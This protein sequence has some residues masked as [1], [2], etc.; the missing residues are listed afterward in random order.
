MVATAALVWLPGNGITGNHHLAS[1]PVVDEALRLQALRGYGVLDTPPEEAFDRLTRLAARLCGAPMAS[2]TLVDEDR[3]WFKSRLGLSFAQTPRDISFCTHGIE[4]REPTVV[5]DAASDERFARNPLVLGEPHLRFYACVPLV[6]PQGWAIGTLAVMDTR[7]R[8]LDPL[9]LEALSALAEQVMTLFELRLREQA[10]QRL[11]A[12]REQMHAALLRQTETLQIAGHLARVGGWIIEIGATQ[13]IWS[14]TVA[15]IHGLEAGRTVTLD[16]ASAFYPEPWRERLLQC[17]RL[18][19]R[20]G[21]SFDE[22]MQIVNVRG[23]S[24]WVRVIGQAVRDGSGR[25]VRVH[26]VLQDISARKRTEDELARS[27]ENFRR[28][29]DAM[30][31]VVWTALPDGRVDYVN[32]SM[33]RFSDVDVPD[34]ERGFNWL[35]TLHPDDRERTKAAWLES[36]RTGKPYQVEY[37]LRH[38]ATTPGGTPTHRWYLSQAEPVRDEQGRVVRWFGSNIDIHESREAERVLLD[39]QR[40]L[41]TLLDN[42]PGMAYRC[43]ISRNWHMDFV[44]EGA[45]ELTGYA[46]AQ[47]VGE[48][49]VHFGDMVVPEDRE[50]VWLE[51]EQAVKARQKFRL[52]Y[53]IRCADGSIKWVQEHGQGREDEDGEVRRLE[54]IITDITELRLAED[55]VRRDAELRAEIVRVQQEIAASDLPMAQ[56]LGLIARSAMEITRATGG[57]IEL[58]EGERLVCH[59]SI[60]LSARPLGSSVGLYDSLGGLAARS[61]QALICDDSETD[62]RVDRR[63]SRRFGARSIVVAPLR[64]AASVIGVLRVTATEPGHFGQ[65]DL[66]HVQILMESLGSTVQRLRITDR[67]RASESQYRLLF[68]QNPSPMWV[69]LTDGLRIQ[70]VNPAAVRHYGYSEAEFLQMSVKDLWPLDQREEIRAKA[71]EQLAMPGTFLLDTRHTRKDGSV[72]DVEVTANV[73]DFNG[74]SAHLCLMADVTERRRV[75]RDLA[76]VSRAQRMLSACN[77]ALIRTED[78]ATLLER[79][80]GITV[81][82]GGYRMAWVGYAMDDA[83]C[84]VVPVSHAGADNGFL[85]GVQVSWSAES[86]YGQGAVGQTVR[87]RSVVIVRELGLSPTS[88]P[89]GERERSHG[90]HSLICLPL[91]RRAESRAFGVLCLFAAEISEVGAE[92]RALLVELADDLA[93]GIEHLR[94]QAEQRRL[95]DTVLK[96]SAAVSASAGEAFFEQLVRNMTEALGASSGFVA[97]YLAAEP[98]RAHTLAAIVQGERIANESFEL[99]GTPCERL[100]EQDSFIHLKGV[101]DAFPA[102]R[103]LQRQGAQAYVGRRLDNARGEPIGLLFVTFS[104]PLDARDFVVSTLQIFAARAA[105]E[106]E[107]LESDRHIRDQAELLDKARD[108]IVLR[109]MGHHIVYW[110]KGAER[111]Y[112]WS[113]AEALGRRT[114]ELL[115]EDTNQYHVAADR[116]MR[117]GEWVGE[118]VQKRK[119]GSLMPVEG[120]WTVVR[121]EAG[122]PRS[123]LGINTD[124]T[125]RKAAE[126]EIQK[127]AFFDSLTGLPNRQLLMD[128]LEHALLNGQRQHSGGAL[129][130]IDL[131]NFKTLNDTLGHDK[132]DQLLQQVAQR[133]S[134]S[135]REVDTVARLGGDEFVILLENLSPSTQDIAVQAQAVGDK[136][137]LAMSTPYR[138]GVYEHQCSSSIGIAPFTPTHGGAGELLR[139]A[140]IAMYQAKAAGRNTLR[141]FDPGLESAVKARA[142]LEADLRQALAHREFLL[143]YQPQVDGQGRLQGVEALLRWQHPV[144]G[145]VSPAGFIPLAEETGLILPIGGWVLQTACA[146]LAQWARDPALS[147]AMGGVTLSVNVSARQFHHPEFVELV[148]DVLRRTGANPRL[149]KLELT[150]S[151]LVE[152]IDDTIAKM[153]ALQSLGVGFSL[154]DFGTGYSSLSYLKRLP[155][156][157][158]KI[159][160][161]FINDV[162]SDGNDSA[163]ARTIIALGHTLGLAVIAEGVETPAQRDFLL[164]HGCNAFQGYL[165]SRPL[166]ADEL[167]AFSRLTREN[168]L[169]RP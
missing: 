68:D 102:A 156:E 15:E 107:R 27:E 41:S 11:E 39:S 135:V 35:S 4:R 2:I 150:E 127:L 126:R 26:G 36:L 47:M 152:D 44:S 154:D 113:A 118:L 122:R 136:V 160:R 111:M 45:R 158:L 18:C 138:L 165:F 49:A 80:C 66:D 144:R 141:F 67:L 117:E 139:Q 81:G 10:L 123:V 105:A 83:D 58:L 54:G 16:E 34:G 59:A 57:E 20:D 167:A 31:L 99:A 25:I 115:Y 29:A 130:F 19:V 89:W 46:P 53:R 96:V 14:D 100:Q 32:R 148:T 116:L 163:I 75:E 114:Y 74:Q 30:P 71:R 147:G 104:K 43:D 92:E 145:L 112:G 146:L 157:Q 128:R 13:L 155:L 119:D 90:Y 159:D 106:L 69:A 85:A 131:D 110:N 133:L 23:E 125:E 153:T 22:E 60:G 88:D 168:A 108:A 1:T 38:R 78:E 142:A 151:L 103:G 5:T 94:A 137:L 40:R 52:S 169:P 50:R 91:N 56:L 93:F 82:I 84:S 77:E 21:A 9:Q 62:S 101:A 98:G 6:T 7:P 162:L 95:Q 124:I 3:Q 42:L 79:I 12:E 24:V 73:I 164:H 161:S 51:V 61:G 63:V 48:G 33:Q 8:M 37:R 121:D 129:L 72:I 76:R 109:D 70:A 64:A 166:P 140:D 65:R 134:D 28:L 97:R 120:R 143:H 132:G 86:P 149:L 17:I 55:L 87:G